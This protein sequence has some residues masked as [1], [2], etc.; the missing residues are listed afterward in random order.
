MSQRLGLV[1]SSMVDK[2]TL[3]SAPDAMGKLCSPNNI[4][5]NRLKAHLGVFACS[6]HRGVV[7]PDYTVLELIRGDE[8]RFIE[9]ALKSA[10]CRRE[11]FIRAK[12]IVEGFWR[13]YTEDLYDIALPV[14]PLDEQ[15]AIVRYLDHVDRR[16]RRYIRAKQKLIKLLEEQR[17]VIIHRAVTRGLD[18]NDR[19]KPSGVE[20]LGEVPEHW[21]IKRL[22]TIS[23]PRSIKNPGNLELLSV[24][25]DRGVIPYHQGGGQV[26]A[27][28]LDLSNYQVVRQGD[29]VLN[30]Q[31]AWRGSVGVSAHD[32]IISPAY[33]VLELSSSLRRLYANHLMRCRSMVDQF[34]ASS[35]GVGDI[36]RTIFWPYLRNVLVPI[37]PV[38]E[39]E[40]I[41]SHIKSSTEEV[42]SA[43]VRTRRE[44]ELIQE[45]RTR[46]IADV[47]TGK[48]DVREAAARLPDEDPDIDDDTPLEPSEAADLDEAIDEMEEVDA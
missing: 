17:Q 28:S 6:N 19:L 5:L 47:V 25:L 2:K 43:L 32:G 44:C 14:P 46:L 9:L 18:P 27:P 7:S 30:N 38:D 36:Q 3:A 34:V 8:P 11:L 26:H 12:G 29:F 13:L 35:K 39:Q 15:R 23:K 31:Q 24:F 37:P 22:W 45:Y 10:P 40:Q 33:V 1:P 41:E 4:V 48:L 16:I 20:W 42:E 21:D